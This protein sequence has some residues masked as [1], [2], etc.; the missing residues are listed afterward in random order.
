MPSSGKVYRPAPIVKPPAPPRLKLD[1]SRVQEIL[2][3]PV[4]ARTV[5]VLLQQLALL[6]ENGISAGAALEVISSQQ[7]HP[8]LINVMEAVTDRI[9]S[10]GWSLSSAMASYP[11]IFPAST[12]MLTRAGETA[13][14]LAARL[15]KA[16]QLL[17]RSANLQA[18]VRQA[19][20]SPMITVGAGML[21][22]F[23]VVKFVMPKFLGLYQQMNL[24]LPALSKLVIGFVHLVNHPIFLLLLALAVGLIWW[25][26]VELGERLFELAVGLP[27]VG[28]WI[29][30]VLCSQFCDI[31]ASLHREGVPLGQAITMLARTAPRRLH[32]R[33]LELVRDRLNSEGSISD[34]IALVPYFPRMMTS[35]CT[36]GEESGSL[37]ELLGSLSRLLEQQVQVVILQVV[38]MIEPLVISAIGVV[39]AVLFVGMFLPVYGVL[40]RL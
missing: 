35:I 25:F 16:G 26:R 21:I 33:Y 23:S 3:G 12:I 37:D 36:V 6:L 31:L 13:G 2:A 17:E 20:T 27:V 38:T 11:D 14:D 8:R 10:R 5:A 7:T 1:S 4:P 22:L 24:E 32:R 18:Q 34:S 15:R 30:V 28:N 9:C 29:G 19:L 39:T 40:A